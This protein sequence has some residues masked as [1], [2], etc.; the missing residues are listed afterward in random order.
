MKAVKTLLLVSVMLMLAD[1]AFAQTWTQ[2]SAPVI[3]WNCLASSADGTKLIGV[4]FSW[5]F[6]TSTNSGSTWTTNTEPQAGGLNGAWS[7]IAM[8]ADGTTCAGMLDNAIWISTNSGISWSSNNIPTTNNLS[9]VVMSADGKKMVAA[10][11]IHAAAPH[12]Y[13]IYTSTN[14]GVNWVQTSAPTNPWVSLACSADGNIIAA[15]SSAPLPLPSI[16]ISTNGGFTWAQ[17]NTNSPATNNWTCVAMSADGGR[18]VAG[19]APVLLFDN[20]Y[21]FLGEIPGLIYTS[22]NFGVTWNSNNVPSNN[23][24][25]TVASSADGRKL[26]AGINTG[27][28]YVSTNFGTTWASVTNLTNNAWVSAASSADGNMLAIASQFNNSSGGFG[29]IYTSQTTP[30][31][32]LSLTPSSP[33]NVTLAWTVPSTNFGL[34]Q[35]TDLASWADVTNPPVLNLT[36]LQN[37][38]TLAPSNSSRFYRLKTP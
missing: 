30:S 27:G 21:N 15:V 8:S 19:S 3:Q 2:T 23:T 1:F 5:Q 4:A 11:G 12:S 37:Q 17:A 20:N 7:S 22:T 16:Y 24:W 14:S 33:T 32:Q 18:L 29:G 9:T 25:A 34:Q 26:V 31:P 10:M 35:S 6:Y 36:N 38:V 28:V 13:N